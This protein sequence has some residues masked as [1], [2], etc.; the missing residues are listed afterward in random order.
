MKSKYNTNLVM[1]TLYYSNFC[2]HSQKIL[3]FLVKENLINQLSFICIDKRSRDPQNNQIY[4][5]LENGKRVIMPPHI[6]NV[7]ALLLAKQNYRVILGEDILRHFSGSVGGNS[8]RSL[9]SLHSAPVEPVGTALMSSNQGMSI[10]SEPYTL[11]SLTSDE[12]SAKGMGGR[13]S[14]Y[15]YVSAEQEVL[16]IQTPPDTYSPDKLSGEVTVDVL[17]QQRMNEIQRSAG[18]NGPF[19]PKL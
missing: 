7:P 19:V 17:Q 12:L 16:T 8:G 5:T 3:Q 14:L 1:D 2:K 4:I 15:N 9:H 13:R 10:L 6:N 18:A 11:Y